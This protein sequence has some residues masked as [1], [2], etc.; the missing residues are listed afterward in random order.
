MMSCS[1]Q[2]ITLN[3]MCSFLE[4]IL[5]FKAAITYFSLKH[6]IIFSTNGTTL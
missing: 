3:L 2:Y 4:Y 1:F 5:K 6:L